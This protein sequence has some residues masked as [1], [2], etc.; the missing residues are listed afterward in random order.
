M[1]T[2][3]DAN[4]ADQLYKQLLTMFIGVRNGKVPVSDFD[5]F[6]KELNVTKQEVPEI[7]PAISTYFIDG[8]GWKEFSDAE[9]FPYDSNGESVLETLLDRF[10]TS[11]EVSNYDAEYMALFNTTN[12]LN[13]EDETMSEQTRNGED[14]NAAADAAAGAAEEFDNEYDKATKTIGDE[15]V[16]DTAEKA[17]T[18]DKVVDFVSTHRTEIAIG[19]AV[20]AA[21]VV[22]V[23]IMGKDIGVSPDV[24]I[25]DELMSSMDNSELF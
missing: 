24:V 13:K 8:T 15:E 22:A 4:T 1:I 9:K 12:K 16:K 20:V 11:R 3:K 10:N 14:K 25:L 19:A 2:G 18:Y 7:A 5:E 21:T 6:L 17:S 23:K